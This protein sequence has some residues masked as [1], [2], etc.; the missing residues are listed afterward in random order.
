M[1]ISYKWLKE[2]IDLTL[3]SEE[4]E[5][6]LTFAGIEVE[7]VEKIG[8]ELAQFK[9]ARIEE[10]KPHPNADKLSVCQVNDGNET[11]QVVCGAPNCAAGQMI[12]FAPVGADLGDFQIKKAKLRGEYSYGMICSEKELGI[13]ENHDGIMV[14]PEDATLGIDFA[15]WLDMS[16]I[17]F[18]VEITPNRPDL[19][20][21]IGVAKDL[22]ALLQLPTKLPQPKLAAGNSDIYQELQL[23]NQAEDLCT[24]YVARMVK[25]VKIA[26][27]PQWLKKRLLAV[28]LRPINN[29]VDITNF[30]MH[31]YG[32]PLH[33]F[34]YDNLTGK[35]IVVRRAA[36]K[37]EF[38]ALDGNNYQLEANDLV[39]ADAEK[40]VALAGIIGGADSGI[41]EKTCN[42]VLEAANF[43]YSNIRKTSGR[44]KIFTDSAYRFE[45]DMADETAEI[46]SQR[47]IELILEIAGGELVAG[48]WDS[49]PNPQALAEVSIRPSRARKILAIQVDKPQITAYLEAL[50]LQKIAE[51]EDLL[52][53][54]IPANRKDLSREI[55]LIEEIIRLHGYNNVKTVLKAQ[56]VM[57]RPYFYT[58]RGFQDLL[59]SFGFS[60][61]VNWSFGDPEDLDILQIP[62]HDDRRDFAS[63]KNPLGAR[64]SILR[65]SLI[66]QLLKNAQYNIDHGIKDLQTFEMAKVF[67]RQDEKLADEKL[68][69]CGLMSG[70][71]NPVFWQGTQQKV[72]FFDLKGIIEELLE[73]LG[74]KQPLF[75]PGTEAFYQRGQTADIYYKKHFLGSFG[76]LD[77]K[78][79]EDF[80]ITQTLYLFDLKFE[81]IYQ[82][83]LKQEPIFSAIPKFP[84]VLRDLSFLVSKQHSVK[85]ITEQ[86]FQ[87]NRK[88]IDDVVL[89]DEY[90]GENVKEGFRSLTFSIVFVS[91]TKTLTDEYTNKIVQKAIK[92]LEKEYQIEMR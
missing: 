51:Q 9:V 47:A 19:L 75:K 18:E 56:N 78:I 40:P 23:E 92:R 39:I 29:V 11:V 35:K 42:I 55:D 14:L 25:N 8:A 10:K 5:E 28:G 82:L 32:H 13:S 16:D 87:A 74:L 60:E 77:P 70:A 63:L 15:T 45:R 67:R 1:K 26:E 69:V 30:V 52:T 84:P 58:R 37:E 31:E 83:Q 66:P 41:T 62:L 89:F 27:S 54:S 85:E 80:G 44:L 76:K 21:M 57:D 72:G 61:L 49:Y 46:I 4:L 65:S 33:A 88:I 90:T 79:A 20:G 86:I 38:L 68:Q 59:V 43:L 22:S 2:Y 3:A 53:F 17:C 64:F 36:E 48:K 73:F 24:R 12:V 50:G 34:D 81:E 6:K 7:A 91:D 71:L